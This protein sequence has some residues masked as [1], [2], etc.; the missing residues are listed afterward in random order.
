MT[1]LPA[2]RKNPMNVRLLLFSYRGRIGRLWYWIGTLAVW[3]G[4]NALG[5]V[6]EKSLR[7]EATT[8]NY[9]RNGV[10]ITETVAFPV[11]SDPSTS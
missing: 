1:P 11:M 5:F 8:F 3:G 2:L 4:T 10:P 7:T 9:V 6:M